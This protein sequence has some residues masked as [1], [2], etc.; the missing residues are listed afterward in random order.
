[1]TLVKA[2]IAQGYLAF[3]WTLKLRMVY[4]KWLENKLGSNTARMAFE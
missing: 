4:Q 2:P 1:M 3:P